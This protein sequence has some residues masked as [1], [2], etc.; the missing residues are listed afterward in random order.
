MPRAYAAS[1]A[2][3]D[4]G[5]AIVSDFDGLDIFGIF[6]VTTRVGFGGMLVLVAWS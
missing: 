5:L 1:R 4:E 3:R 2:F 6:V